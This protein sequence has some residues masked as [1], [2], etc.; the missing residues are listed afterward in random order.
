MFSLKT[1]FALVLALALEAAYGGPMPALKTISLERDCNGCLSGSRLVLHADGSAQMA[2]LGKARLG[3]ADSLCEGRV[4]IE[5]V[6]GLERLATTRSFLN[7]DAE[8][9]DPQLQ[10]G[11]WL[12]LRVEYADGTIKQ[13]FSRGE[14]APSSLTQLVEAV[15]AAGRQIAFDTPQAKGEGCGFRA[16]PR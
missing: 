7:L 14:T 8:I 3:T 13:V 12:T 10:D 5:A 6:E 9:A 15:D 4:S 2:T 16:T 11:P 1:P